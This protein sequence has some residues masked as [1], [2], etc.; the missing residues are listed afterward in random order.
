MSFRCRREIGADIL[1]K[2]TCF[3]STDGKKMVCIVI[4]SDILTSPEEGFAYGSI[5]L[6]AKHNGF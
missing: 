4:V 6:D 5:N 2:M 1:A 3:Y